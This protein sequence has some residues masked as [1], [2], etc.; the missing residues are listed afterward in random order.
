MESF[1]NKLKAKN[2]QKRTVGL[3]EN[4]TWAPTAGKSMKAVLE[5]MKEVKIAER[6]VTVKSALKPGDTA[7]LEALADELLA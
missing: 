4:G 6:M 1:L 7:Q 2:Y 3:I 5:G